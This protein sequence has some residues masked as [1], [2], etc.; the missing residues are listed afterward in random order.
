MATLELD[1]STP[2]GRVP[3]TRPRGQ[4]PAAKETARTAGRLLPL[5][6][7]IALM[8][9]FLAGP[10]GYALYGS[11]TNAALS[12]YRAA[13]PEFVG[14]DNYT[15]LLTSG[16]F[17]H[18]AWLTL[19]FVGLSA[20]V[21]QNVLGMFLAVVQNHAP[22]PVANVVGALVV[23]AWVM[24]EIVAAFALYAFFAS[25]GTLN[26]G[27]EAVGLAPAS[28]LIDTP[29]L[30][31]ILANVWRGTAFSM[32]V[33][34]AALAEVPPEIGE[35]AQIDGASAVQRFFRITLPMVRRAISTNMM[36]TTL[37]TLGTFTLIFVMTSG[38]PGN[39]STTLPV[40]AFQEAFKLAQI[41]YGTAIAVVTLAVGALFAVLYVRVLKPEV[42]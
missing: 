23:G 25:D 24:P 26:A 27:L 2:R 42:D 18:A 29:M 11:L 38:G 22:K 37:Q 40:L 36:L 12:G 16:D 33:F 5:T 41:G 21:G 7:A 39:R 20:V 6:P 4:R 13:N 35:A 3:G 34:N 14:I 28:W 30:A 8:G 15:R 32:L 9:V 10:I 1:G 31:V 19:L 17:W